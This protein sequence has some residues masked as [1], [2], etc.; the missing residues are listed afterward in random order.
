MVGTCVILGRMKGYLRKY[1]VQQDEEM[2][3]DRRC[4]EL[5][6]CVGRNV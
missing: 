5:I 3:I 2:L 4:D 1:G 6:V